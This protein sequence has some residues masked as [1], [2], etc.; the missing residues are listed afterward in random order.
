M[1]MN[2]KTSGILCFLIHVVRGFQELCGSHP[3]GGHQEQ[4]QYSIEHFLEGKG[5]TN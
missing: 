4:N 3:G 1:V 5:A 2:R